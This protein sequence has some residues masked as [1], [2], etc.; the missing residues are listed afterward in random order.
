[1]T[2]RPIDGAGTVAGSAG[3]LGGGTLGTGVGAGRGGV[4]AGRGGA[5]CVG[6]AAAGLEA[7]SSLRPLETSPSFA[8]FAV[9]WTAD[10]ARPGPAVGAIAGS[11][12]ETRGPGPP[13]GWNPHAASPNA[14]TT[15]KTTV[16]RFTAP[17]PSQ[18]GLM[19]PL[20][21]LR[22]HATPH[23]DGCASGSTMGGLPDVYPPSAERTKR[24]ELP[25]REH[26]RQEPD[27]HLIAPQGTRTHSLH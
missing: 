24:T 1:M 3:W 14:A 18:V 16:Q 15:P 13:K 4:G 23:R 8:G 10:A 9:G 7:V 6:C 19:T 5:G 21:P 22:F 26:Q 17:P 12:T 25:D 11:G 27:A 20:A 2:I